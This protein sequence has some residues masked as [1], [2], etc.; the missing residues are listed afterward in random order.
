M[1]NDKLIS[2]QQIKKEYGLTNTL[3]EKLGNPDCVKLNPRY[4]SAPPMQQY[5]TSRVVEF[6]ENNIDIIAKTKIRKNSANKAVITKTK[7]SYAKLLLILQEFE[8][9]DKQRIHIKKLAINYYNNRYGNY[10]DEIS[11]RAMCSFIRH[12]LTN[13]DEI[14]DSISGLVGKSTL[15][16]LIKLYLN[17][18]II[19]KYILQITPLNATFRLNEP[20]HLDKLTKLPNIDILLEWKSIEIYDYIIS[21]IEST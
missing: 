13:Y 4:R 19:E 20:N 2:K 1:T 8:L 17:S 21:V 11:E 15:Y 10:D 14:L 6:I 12:Q 18:L 3:I 9:Q 7:K 16:L 5:L